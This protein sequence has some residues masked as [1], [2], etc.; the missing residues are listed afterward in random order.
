MTWWRADADGIVLRVRATPGA[1]RSE[2]LAPGDDRLRVR[3]AAPA[4]EGKANAELIRTIAAWCGVRRS[5]VRIERGER[6]REKT[7]RVDG[8]R[9]PPGS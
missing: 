4:V 5:A 3:V 7:V 6:G 2:V 9:A 1:K 8:L